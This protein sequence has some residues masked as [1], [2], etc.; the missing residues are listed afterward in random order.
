ML[1]TLSSFE[2]QLCDIQGR[3]FEL[4]IEKQM[5]SSIFIER[6]MNSETAASI[7][8]SYDRLQWM[9]E[10]YILENLEDEVG[11]LKKDNKQ[12]T[13]DV[14]Y[15]IGYTYRYWHY[16]TGETS[17]EIYKQ[18]NEIVMSEAYLWFHTLD[19]RMA[20][21]DLKNLYNQSEIIDIN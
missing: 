7:D 8:Q 6:F 5:N 2:R 1:K 11:L 9:G 16:M 12:Y 18:A 19:M 13:K 10:E 15:W 4:S 3:L 17:K 20:V 14:M 21:E